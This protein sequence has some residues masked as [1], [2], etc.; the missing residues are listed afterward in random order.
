MTDI[1]RD[2]GEARQDYDRSRRAFLDLCTRM[3]VSVPPAVLLLA[4][5]REAL[6]SH[7]AGED[8]RG[9]PPGRGR[10]PFA[11]PPPERGRPPFSRRP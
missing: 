1:E 8:H 10:P 3:S 9:P 2:D 11:G 5:S 6:A 7:G 4:S